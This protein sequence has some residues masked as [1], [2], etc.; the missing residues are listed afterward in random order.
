MAKVI[1]QTTTTEYNEIS[2]NKEDL[3][4]AIK[5]M[6]GIDVPPTAYLS[7]M[8]SEPYYDMDTAEVVGIK[9]SWSETKKE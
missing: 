4:A 7:F 3:H 8:Y 9:L 2:L 1:V 5:I 6:L